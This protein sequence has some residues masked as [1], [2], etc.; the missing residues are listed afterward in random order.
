MWATRRVRETALIAA[1]L[2]VPLLFLR[3]NVAL[4]GDLN[5]V[6]KALLR[7]SAPVQAA[8][9]GVARKVH[10]IWRGYLYLVDLRRDNERLRH[11]NARLRAEV[12]QSRYLMERTARFERLLEL[13][14]ELPSET[15]A[16]RVIARETSPF[17]RVVRIRLDRGS[18]PLRIGMPVI[19]PEG[20]VGR[21]ERTY[22]TYSDVLLAI[23]PKSAIDV[24]VEPS[25]A[26]GIAKGLGSGDS[27]GCTL[28]YL[29]RGEPVR[30][31]DRVVTSG[32]GGTF[33]RNLEVGRV[34]R[35]LREGY[36]MYQQV[37]VTPAVDFARLDEVLVVLAAPPTPDPEAMRHPRE[38][39]RG[40]WPGR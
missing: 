7:L 35:V 14:T 31:G 6:D 4:P 12:V 11:D 2:V 26:R 13:R 34:R 8:A 5:A 30:P 40:L 18:E 32:Q 10:D 39:A 24:R 1:L 27:Y 28:Q 25:G 3:A 9:T 33:P 22:G 37:E 16:A 38:P 17:F 21:V 36:G 23:D 29:L 19:A 15:L 20:I